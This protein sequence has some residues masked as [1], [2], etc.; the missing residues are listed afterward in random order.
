[1]TDPILINLLKIEVD[2]QKNLKE[3]LAAIE[4]IGIGTQRPPVGHY[5]WTPEGTFRFDGNKYVL[6]EVDHD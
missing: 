6:T 4:S 2:K 1:M 3:M 5:I